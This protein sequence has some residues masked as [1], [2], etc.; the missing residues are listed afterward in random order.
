MSAKSF[1]LQVIQ[2]DYN[3]LRP[4]MD[5]V[6]IRGFGS[7]E[8]QL[9]RLGEKYSLYYGTFS[10]N[11]KYYCAIPTVKYVLLLPAC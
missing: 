2:R 1:C 6:P 9:R 5:P 4:T 10:K 8:F 7:S 11:N 3:G